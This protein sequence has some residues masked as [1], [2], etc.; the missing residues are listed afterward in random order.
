MRLTNAEVFF[1]D[2]L[3]FS[4]LTKGQVLG[5]KPQDFEAWG[6]TDTDR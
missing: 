3:G 2:I 5:I 6:L 4:A 1:V